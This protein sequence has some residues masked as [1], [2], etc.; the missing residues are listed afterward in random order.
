MS[1]RTY[2]PEEKAKLMQVIND[3]VQVKSEV[4]SLNEGLRDTVKAVAEEIDVKPGLINKAISIAHK[5]NWGE[6]SSDFDDLESIITITGRD[7]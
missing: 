4:E 7:K 1:S 5:A 2:G 6:V 3:G